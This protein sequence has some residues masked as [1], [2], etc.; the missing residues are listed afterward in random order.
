M[1]ELVHEEHIQTVEHVGSVSLSAI[2][3]KLL[4]QSFQAALWTVA[5]SMASYVPALNTLKFGAVQNSLEVVAEKLQFVKCLHTRFS[6]LPMSV[7]ITHEAKDSIIPACIAGYHHQ[8]LYF[9]S[10]SKTCIL[11]AEPPA[12]LS[13]LDVIAIVVSQ[14]LGSPTPLPI[15]SLFLCP[16]GSEAAMVDILKLCSDKKDTETSVG[17]CS[18]IGKDVSPQ[19]GRQV[20][21][22]PLRPF[23]AGEIVAWRL[24]NGEKLKYG[25]VPEDVRPSAGQ[26][27]YRFTVETAPG[28]TQ[29]LLSS[30]VLSFRTAS[31]SGG[32]APMMLLEDSRVSTVDSPERGSSSH[33][34]WLLLISFCCVRSPFSSSRSL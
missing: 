2:R 11:V 19:D 6:L 32:E 7:D 8:R 15:G 5:Q 12:F 22:H 9:V 30:Q 1:Q 16:G 33:Q 25:R 18:L 34:V 17:K 10:W 20:Q 27:V 14:V 13:I 31:M 21:F 4:S 26:A 23:Y 3:D 24:Q 29:P 28:E